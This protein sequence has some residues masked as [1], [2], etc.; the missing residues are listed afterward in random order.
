[1][2]KASTPRIAVGVSGSGSNLRALVAVGARG[3]LGG[4]I[5]VV[6]AD[7]P[8]AALDWAAE[9]GIETVLVPGGEDATLADTLAALDL[10]AVVLAGYLRLVGPDVLR[11]FGGRIL[12]VHPSLLPAFPGLHAVR[13]ALGAGVAVTGVTVHLVD[14]TLDGGPIVAQEGVPVLPGDDEAALLERLHAVE[15]RLLPSAVAALLAGALSVTLGAR[16]ATLDPAAFDAHAPT[17]R[18]ALVSVSDKAG[19]AGFGA[20]LVARGFELVSTGGTAR[21]LREAGLPVTDVAAVTGFPEMLDGRVKT[22]HPRVHAGL[23]ADRRRADHREALAAAGIAPFELVVVNLYPF[24]EAARKP[25]LSL[26]ELVEEIDIGGPSMVRAAAKNHAS[27]AIVTSPAR[28]D[29]VLGALD[30]HGEVPIGLRSALAIEAF[31]HTAAYDARIAAELPCRMHDAGIALPSEP[32]LPGAEDPYPPV[33]TISMAKVETLRYGE[34]PHQPAARYRRTDR[35]PRSAEGPFASGEPPL[36]GKALSYNNVLDASA[37]ASLARLLRGPGVVIV[38]HTNPCGAAERATLHEAWDAA[39]AGDPVSAFGGVVAITGPVD[40]ALAERLTSLFLEVVVA[41]AFD[42]SALEVL[43]TKP[44]LRLVED[45]SLDAAADR[46]GLTARGLLD[47]DYLGS[48][49]TAGGAVLVTAPDRQP[50]DAAG[51]ACV[52]RRTPTDGE[53]GDLDLAWRLCRGVVSNAIVLVRDGMLV[54]LGSGQVSRVDACRGAVDKARQFQGD[55][56]ARGAVAASD[57]FFPFADGPQL[58]LDA[59]VSA[60]VQPGGS[61]RDAEVLAAVDAAG[62]AMLVT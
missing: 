10:D 15:H 38:K 16:R 33:L 2:S 54:G 29:A 32:G 5:V 52:S 40:R 35:E 24:A 27:V 17:P 12:N 57:A 39:L 31:A 9:Q 61:M 23:L 56:G 26:D 30:E 62:A 34:N 55:D 48:V 18:R 1:M 36:Q 28:Y 37:A 44:N 47:V 50:D 21:A 8:C 14:A 13:D 45:P 49:R 3:A 20:G 6:F 51:W 7:R 58:L 46:S 41:P 43:A 60:I 42:A 19:L 4:D 53:R 25:G 59:G 11:R 22:L